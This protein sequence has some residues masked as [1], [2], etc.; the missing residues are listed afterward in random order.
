MS[1]KAL[2]TCRR[3]AKYVSE[4]SRHWRRKSSPLQVGRMPPLHKIDSGNANTAKLRVQM[5]D[6]FR[7]I[8]PY[9]YSLSD[10]TLLVQNDVVAFEMMT[11]FIRSSWKLTSSQK[12]TS[13]SKIRN[14]DLD[15]PV[16]AER[17]SK[18]RK[19]WTVYSK[20]LQSSTRGLKS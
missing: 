11:S 1:L 17:Q 2:W 3:E 20:S 6:F 14:V 13:S 4:T 5:Q 15:E 8:S 18:R 19:V 12:T 9:L 7:S 10:E 16:K